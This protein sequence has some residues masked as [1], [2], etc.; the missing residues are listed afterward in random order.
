MTMIVPPEIEVDRPT[1]HE[2]FSGFWEVYEDCHKHARKLVQHEALCEH[3][4][5]DLLEGF[6]A[7][8]YASYAQAVCSYNVLQRLA[9]A[10]VINVSRRVMKA[11]RFGTQAAQEQFARSVDL[12]DLNP[13][14]LDFLSRNDR[15]VLQYDI[16]DEN[17]RIAGALIYSENDILSVITF[18]DS[19]IDPF[20]QPGLFGLIGRVPYAPIAHVMYPQADEC[21]FPVAPLAWVALDDGWG[22]V[23]HD[24]DGFGDVMYGPAYASNLHALALLADTLSDKVNLKPFQARKDLLADVEQR[25]RSLPL[26]AYDAR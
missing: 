3:L 21:D 13:V 26:V 20:N 7:R 1:L 5:Q 16:G 18:G 19:P 10:T 2:S 14:Y 22:F 11:D 6:D 12:G 25:G 8:R 23:H 15:R 4:D 24:I 9:E 17:T